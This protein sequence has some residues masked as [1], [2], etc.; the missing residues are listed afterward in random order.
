MAST[1]RWK[2]RLGCLTLPV[3]ILVVGMVLL[4]HF[5][6]PDSAKLKEVSPPFDAHFAEYLDAGYVTVDGL[7]TT[8]VTAYPQVDDISLGELDGYVRGKIVVV[9]ATTRKMDSIFLALPV[10]LAAASHEDVGTVVLVTYTTLQVS[11]YEG[12]AKGLQIRCDVRVAD[13]KDKKIVGLGSFWGEFPPYSYL[14]TGKNED[15]TGRA[16]TEEVVAYLQ[17]LPRK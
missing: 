17:A 3:V 6:P 4:Y 9:D 13:F 7:T 11:T 16:P 15:Q 12:G 1:G 14:K 5:H 10:E 2:K 8:E